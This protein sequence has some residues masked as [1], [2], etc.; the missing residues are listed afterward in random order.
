MTR[1]F[2]KEN[3]FMAGK[4]IYAVFSACLLFFKGAASER[5]TPIRSTAGK[6]TEQRMPKLSPLPE[7]SESI[8]TKEGPP[9]QPRSPASAKKANIAAP[10]PFSEAAAMLNVPGHMI[11]TEN[12][13]MP[14]PIRLSAAAGEREIT[15]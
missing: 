10:P 11:P 3:A 7:D 14:Q 12:P 4:Y 9:E 6:T 1:G 8:P 15:K 2:E 5:R 13:Q